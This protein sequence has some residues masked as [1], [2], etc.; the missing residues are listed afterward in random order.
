MR[1]ALLMLIILLALIIPAS[2]D[3]LIDEEEIK[4]A[5]PSDIQEI[6]DDDTD[7]SL[8]NIWSELKSDSLSELK[9]SGKRAVS[10]I[11]VALICGVLTVF[12]ISKDAPDYIQLCGCAAIALICVGD[13][14]SY[15]DIAVNALNDLDIFSKAMLPAM[16]TACAACGAVNAAAAK[17]A[18]SA[19]FMDVFV[20]A[21]RN[22]IV[23]LIYA[24]IAVVIAQAA[25]E[26][27]SLDGVGKFLK[28]GCTSLMTVFTLAFTVYLS[29]SSAISSSADAVTTKVAKTA[30]SAALP[31]VGGIISDAASSVVAGAEVIKNTA[32]VFGLIV[33]LAICAAPFALLGI[34]FLVYKAAAVGVSAISGTRLTNLISGLGT[35]FGMLLAVLGC[36]G[37]FIFISIM[38][39]VKAVSIVG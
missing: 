7:L 26:N 19:L 18:A 17:Y 32:G 31:V 20:T 15:V 13:M 35:A 39:C 3:S 29:I 23:P 9:Q 30:I 16:C 38:S 10:I 21:V 2:A 34:N 11:V 25:F 28:W 5:V 24:Y 37:I 22:V 1:K 27:K 36:C 14:G 8:K 6:V 33:V 4:D 12:E